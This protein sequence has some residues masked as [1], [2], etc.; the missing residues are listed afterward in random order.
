[1]SKQ[2]ARN[3]L[4]N[5]KITNGG[6]SKFCAIDIDDVKSLHRYGFKLSNV[7]HLVQIPKQDMDFV[8]ERV[9]PDYITIYDVDKARQI[10]ESARRAGIVQKLILRVVGSG[11][12]YYPTQEGGIFENEIVAAART[13]ESFGGL[14][15]AG[16]TSYPCFRFN[17]VTRSEV[18]LP[19]LETVKRAV[20]ALRKEAGC[21]I[22]IVSAPGDTCSKTIPMISE[23]GANQGEPGHAFLGTTPLHFF[24]ETLPEKASWVYVSEVSH[25]FPDRAFAFGGGAT[26]SDFIFGF[27]TDVFQ[28]FYLYALVGHDPDNILKREF[29]MEPNPPRTI[30]YHLTIKTP[31]GDTAVGDTVICGPRPQMFVV[32]AW[33]VPVS[34]I[35]SGRPKVQG[36]FDQRGNVVDGLGTPQDPEKVGDMM[37]KLRNS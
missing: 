21:E 26:Y 13:I 20:V 30:D 10:S 34:G 4:V 18:V 23:N 6:V 5:V 27:W 1:M 16:V 8:V 7:G 36:I 37:T 11:D 17:I 12:F 35:N 32:R 3:P 22:E 15:V 33:V 2:H 28:Q 24:D 14:K 19:N 9:R 31:G 25:R 29:L